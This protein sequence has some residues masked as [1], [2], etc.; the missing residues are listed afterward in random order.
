MIT[1]AMQTD[2][3]AADVERLGDSLKKA[4]DGANWQAAK[5]A[6]DDCRQWMSTMAGVVTSRMT[7]VFDL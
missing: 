2:E 6:V 3:V 4:I 5:I 1:S 7:R